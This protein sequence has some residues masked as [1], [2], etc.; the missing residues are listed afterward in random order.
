MSY[1]YY[2]LKTIKHHNIIN[3]DII[4]LGFKKLNF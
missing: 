3:T 2:I 4:T 1:L